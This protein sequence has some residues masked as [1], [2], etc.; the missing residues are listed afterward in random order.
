MKNTRNLLA[1]LILSLILSACGPRPQA[2]LAKSDLQRV[3]NPDVPAD[4]LATLVNGNNAFAFD[5]YQSLRAGD[6]NLILS[7]YNI[8]LTLAMT[9]AGASGETETQMARALHFTL[10]QD[11]LN[12]AFNQLDTNLSQE[13]QSSATDR[14]PLQLNIANAVWAEQTFPFLQTY[15]DLIA[16]NYGAGIHLADFIHQF[17]RVRTQIN[18]W[19]SDQTKGK[20]Q[21]LIPDGALNADT[22]MVL[23]NAI[24]FKADWQEPFD[25]DNTT[26]APFHIL[27]GSQVDVKTMNDTLHIPYSSGDGYQAV[28]LPYQNGTAAMDILVPDTG[29]FDQFESTITA[30]SFDK[31]RNDMQPASVMLSLPKFTFDSQFS[32]SDQLTTLGMPDAFDANKADFSGMTGKQDLFISNVVHKANITVDEK[33]TEAAAATGVIMQATSA[34]VTQINLQ[35]DRPF[36]YVIRDLNSGQI[37]FIGRVLNPM[38]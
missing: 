9:Y 8:S 16:Q 38:W 5:L 21:N 33:G 24:Y 13:G 12:P 18:N 35:I 10:P 29:N 32:L 19:V 3:E 23:V 7:P 27:D 20:I 22:R 36:L 6:G 2:N 28:E 14:Q 34:M 25:P 31:I 4:D 17:P 15:L 30:E 1:L 37:L 11:R 26:N